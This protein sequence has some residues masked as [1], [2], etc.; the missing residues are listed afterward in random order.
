LSPI[1]PKNG[2]SIDEVIQFYLVVIVLDPIKSG[3]DHFVVIVLQVPD[4]K[5]RVLHRTLGKDVIDSSE[6]ISGERDPHV[7]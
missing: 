4:Q 2:T 6:I 3:S 1:P 5:K 7:S